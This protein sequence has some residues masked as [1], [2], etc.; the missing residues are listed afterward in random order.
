MS[1]EKD[2]TGIKELF[3]SDLGEGALLTMDSKKL[4]FVDKDNIKVEIDA[5]VPVQKDIFMKKWRTFCEENGETL[6][7]DYAEHL[8]IIKKIRQYQ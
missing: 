7:R 6:I 1:L 5:T 3:T 2:I 4:K 8:G